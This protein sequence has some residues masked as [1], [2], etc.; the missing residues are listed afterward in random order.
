MAELEGDFL[1]D[2]KSTG[3]Y[4]WALQ[5][6]LFVPAIIFLALWGHAKDN[7]TAVIVGLIFSTIFHC[8]SISSVLINTD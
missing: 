4:F 6:V 1:Q 7:I 5:I 3:Q 8:S 2:T